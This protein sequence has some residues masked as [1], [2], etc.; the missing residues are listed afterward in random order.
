MKAFFANPRVQQAAYAVA[1]MVV[2]ALWNAWNE[3]RPK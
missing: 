3:H 2:T 1:H